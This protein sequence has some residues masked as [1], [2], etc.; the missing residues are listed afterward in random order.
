M[1]ETS[2][3]GAGDDRFLIREDEAA[4]LTGVCG[5]P[6]KR[7]AERGEAV[8]RRKLGRATVYHKPTL[9]AWAAALGSPAPTT[10]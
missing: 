3:P 10:A 2:T 5:R 1:R 6:L 7:A 8:G 9:E 4:R